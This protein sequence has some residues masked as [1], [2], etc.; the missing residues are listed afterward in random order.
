MALRSDRH[1]T[2]PIAVLAPDAGTTIGPRWATIHDGPEGTSLYSQAGYTTAP[3]SKT[4]RVAVTRLL[5][6]RSPYTDC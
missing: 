5:N 4:T 2:R 1:R 6:G 3:E